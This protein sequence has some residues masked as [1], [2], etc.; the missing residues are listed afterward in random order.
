VCRH[1]VDVAVAPRASIREG[2][3]LFGEM[4][5]RKSPW[6]RGASLASSLLAAPLLDSA[7]G[8]ELCNIIGPN[9]HVHAEWTKHRK[10]VQG[11][12]PVEDDLIP[13][14]SRC[15]RR[16][17]FATG[18]S[19]SAWFLS[20]TAVSLLGQ[21]N[22]II[23]RPI[24]KAIEKFELDIAKRNGAYVCAVRD[25]FMKQRGASVEYEFNGVVEHH[26]GPEPMVS[27]TRK[28]D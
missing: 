24:G 4:S 14:T 25:D 8:A 22:L 27:S 7:R 28:I 13:R 1:R 23:V 19:V 10:W 17:V 5:L 15:D 6:F 3:H 16:E 9:S 11:S 26:D 12:A 20:F 2:H 21:N 18:R